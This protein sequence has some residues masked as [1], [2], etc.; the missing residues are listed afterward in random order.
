MKHQTLTL[1]SFFTLLTVGLLYV[2]QGLPMG[3]AMDF[4]PTILRANGA[5]LSLLRWLPLI[6]V[7]WIIKFLWASLVDNYWNATLGKRRSWIIPMQA[8]VV[9][10]L[11]LVAMVG[12]SG[13]S[14][15]LIL[16]LFL[17][18][19]LVAATQD[20][21]TDGLIAERFAEN[22]LPIA[23]AVQMAGVLTGF[24]VGGNVTLMA[25]NVLGESNGILVMIAIPISGILLSLFMKTEEDSRQPVENR[26]KANLLQFV[27]RP[28]AKKLLVISATSATLTVGGFTLGKL[29]LID[30]GWSMFEVGQLGILSGMVTILVGCGGIVLAIFYL[31][32]SAVTKMSVFCALIASACWLFIALSS[33]VL[34]DLIIYTAVIL[35]AIAT[36]GISVCVMTFAATFAA[37]GRQSGTDMATV[38]SARDTGEML[39]SSSAITL[40]AL[41][42]YSA[43]FGIWLCLALCVLVVMRR[44]KSPELGISC[45]TE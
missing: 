30:N 5:D 31:G 10:L 17:L 29:F 19:S 14:I 22:M 44:A 4:L 21:A 28:G 11:F 15:S 34:N 9:S 33:P 27:I 38:Q 3:L 20:I 13:Q 12:F 32:L 24:F 16:C 45:A 26:S 2:C 42:G 40:V 7:P 18:M 36:G 39:A 6:G 41:M 1:R 25:V 43:T 23:N 37:A 35:G 8:L